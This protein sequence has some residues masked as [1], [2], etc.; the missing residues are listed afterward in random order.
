MRVVCSR[1]NH[2]ITNLRSIE[3]TADVLFWYFVKPTAS[4]SC[5]MLQREYPIIPP[6]SAIYLLM[7]HCALERLAPSLVS[8][9]TP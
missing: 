9:Y 8:T 6:T 1:T 5:S 4:Y 2:C 3:L 7:M